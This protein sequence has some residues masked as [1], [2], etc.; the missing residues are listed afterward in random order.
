MTVLARLAGFRPDAHSG[1]PLYIQVANRLS[2]G[3]IGGDWRAN[4]AL[5]SERMLLHITRVSYLESGAAV[6]LTHSY[7]RND[8]YEYVAEVRR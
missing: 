6:D 1:T 5:P 2:S 3:I 8:Y 7:C 4:Q